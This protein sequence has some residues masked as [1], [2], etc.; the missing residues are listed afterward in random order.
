MSPQLLV[1]ETEP[2]FETMNYSPEFSTGKMIKV[3]RI[4]YLETLE[5]GIYKER[6]LEMEEQS[7]VKHSVQAYFGFT[8]I[9]TDDSYATKI[10][11]KRPD[12][13]TEE[14]VIPDKKNR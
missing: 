10:K 11:V 3:V 4:D 2:G 9:P 14:V 7:T 6:R 1:R 5:K 8:R 13:H 12:G